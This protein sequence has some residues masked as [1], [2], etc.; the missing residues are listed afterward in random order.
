MKQKLLSIFLLCIMLAGAAFAQDRKITGKVTAKEDGLPLPGVSV[1]VTGTKLGT[2][3]DAN[4]TYSL[5]VPTGSKSLEVSFVGFLPQTVTIGSKSVI[6]VSLETDNKQ[7]S[8]VVVVG[9]GQQSKV[10][11]TSSVSSI[12]SESFK[13]TPINSPQ[14][15][16]QGQAAG[17]NM[18]NSSGILGAAAAITIRGGSSINAGGAPLFVVD[19]V[20][21][22]AG[23]YSYAQGGGAG[24]N[25]LLNI[26]SDDIESVNVLKD[27]AA[28]AIYGSR[29]SNGVIIINTKSGKLNSATKFNAN[30]FSGTSQPTDLLKYMSADQFRQF[31]TDYLTANGKSVPNYPTT[32]FDWVK[33]VVRTGHVNTANVSASGGS[34]KTTFFVGG[35]YSKES[36]YTIGN[37]LERL[38]GRINLE[39]HASKKILF[40]LNYNLSDVKSGRA[41]V[42][43]NTYA[44]LTSSYLQ[45]PYVT[46]FDANGNYVN[47]GFIQ[48]VLAIQA[49]DINTYGSYRSTGNAYAQWSILPT[50]KLKTD[51]GIDDIETN[52]KYREVDLLTPGGYGYKTLRKDNKWLNTTTLN[53]SQTFGGKHTITGLLGYSYETSNYSDLL[54]EG[55]GFASDA[56]PNVG[57]ASNPITASETGTQWALE[58]QFA[59][60]DYNYSDKYL[61]EGSVRRDGSSRFGPNKKYGIFYAG[62][63]AW[64]ISNEAFLKDSKNIN[65]LKLRASY[66]TAGNDQI[67]NF[68]YLGL[69]GSGANYNGNSGL[70]PNQVP[71]PNLS[72]EETAQL[73][74]G[75]QA[76]LF[77]ILDINLDYYNKLTTGLLAA[78]PYPYTTGFSSNTQNVGKMRNRGL[79]L[80][81]T[82]DNIKSSNFSWTTTLNI[83]YNK[84]SVLSLPENKDDDGRN[85]LAGSASQRAI[86]G[87]SKNTFF[88]IR[89]NGVDPQTGDATWLKKDGTVTTNPTAA[90]RVIVGHADPSYVGGFTNNFRYKN[91]DLSVFFNYALG[92]KV[93]IDGLRFTENYTTG[94]FNK[95]TDL[96]NYWKKPGD[97]VFAPA[98][99]SPTAGTFAQRSTL[100]MQNGSYARLKTVSLGYNLPKTM[101]GKT[102]FVRSARIYALAQNLFIIQ[103]KG[104]RGPDPEVSANGGNNLIVGESFFALPQSKTFTF[105]INLGF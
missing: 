76:R 72:W 3:T 7:L 45:V 8:E 105:G 73:D 94:S 47:T 83:A 52:E 46:P 103:A 33:A 82:S 15:I 78:V 25:P 2:Q 80:A 48:N 99:T 11:T 92:N 30:F 13:N 50:L 104:F 12:S 86:E 60:L 88:L 5:N 62:S 16:L 96:L 41:G 17:V 37:D 18:V 95:S 64:V 65:L 59:R 22:N 93:F 79:E 14:Q 71:N 6:N 74:I 90:D 21:L 55:T 57:S 31:R 44:P 51:F 67:G 102:K 32:S 56:L 49:L 19:G 68:S 36:G 38:S 20:P 27:A 9:Y 85:F 10:L 58:S 34:D 4:G 69:Y 98:L 81:I 54:V 40:G 23:S 53:Y 39:H 26:N 75:A 1:K 63:A 42:E 77:N 29:G 87:Y 84:N 66:G 43:N 35:T 28:T 97:N 100:Q 101:L 61:L 24:L 70:S 89:Y 91:F